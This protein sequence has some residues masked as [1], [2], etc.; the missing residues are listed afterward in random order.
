MSYG[1]LRSETFYAPASWLSTTKIL[2]I[3]EKRALLNCV[4]I[5][6]HSEA[7]YV[8][9]TASPGEERMRVAYGQKQGRRQRNGTREK[10]RKKNWSARG[11]GGGAKLPDWEGQPI[12]NLRSIKLGWEVRTRLS[13][14]G[15]RFFFFS[16]TLFY[17]FFFNPHSRPSLLFAH[18]SFA[19][20]LATPFCI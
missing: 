2:S 19:L 3:T 8:K 17:P 1:V 13:F 5:D 4:G 15:A 9:V 6:I 10:P 18:S 14:I 11:E 16:L 12:R 20:V 7:C